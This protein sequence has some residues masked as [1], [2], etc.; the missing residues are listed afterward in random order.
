MNAY[1]LHRFLVKSGDKNAQIL[2]HEL[3]C[4]DNYSLL[5]ISS[6]DNKLHVWFEITQVFHRD[7]FDLSPLTRLI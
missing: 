2:T 7:T 4:V 1:S 6:N 3:V 5:Q